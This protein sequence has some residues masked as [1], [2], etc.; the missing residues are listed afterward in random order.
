MKRDLPSP[1]G[2]GCYRP[3]VARAEAPPS[4]PLRIWAVRV[5]VLAVVAVLVVV[6]FGLIGQVDW[7]AVGRAVRRLTWWQVPL[8]VV[9]I[10]IRQ[11]VNSQPLA[12]YIAGLTPYRAVLND[13]VGTMIGM[14]IPT[15]S[16]LVIRSAMYSS[17][18]VPIA[19]GIAGTLLHKVTFYIVRYGIPVV[20]AAILLARG[21]GLGL[22]LF[23]LASVALSIGI[24]VV[25]LLVMHSTSLA[26]R[27]GRRAGRLVARI[28]RRVDPEAWAVS[29]SAFHDNVAARF[30]RGFG[31]AVLCL[32]VMLTL[33]ST[34]VVL[35]MRFVGVGPV[36]PVSVI[37]A[38]FLI[39][40]PLT[41]FPF[42]GIGLI[43]AAVV[44]G[45]VATGGHGVEAPAVAAMLVWRVFAV[46][47]PILM[48]LASILVWN[49]RWGAD[50]GLWRSIRG[51]SDVG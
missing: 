35:A 23:D 2:A 17:W 47:G 38:A 25:L 26:A 5:V 15:P 50:V 28:R 10:V 19:L 41:L 36:V 1:G 6:A 29:W 22:R 14:L 18:G 9:L 33:D 45:V 20:G 37:V 11:S 27:V 39:A 4:S 3:D 34:M 13:Q 7:D 32:L 8:L 40:F 48:G 49:H 42:N 51:G 16:D 31:W 24:L 12:L 30:H 21:D 43:E 46:G 44:A